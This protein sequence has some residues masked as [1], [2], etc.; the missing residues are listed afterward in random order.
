[1]LLL[2]FLFLPFFLLLPSC[3]CRT[4][5]S[6]LTVL[7]SAINVS[8]VCVCLDEKHVSH[9]GHEDTHQTES[10]DGQSDRRE[11]ADRRED[12]H[13]DLCLRLFVLC[14]AP[15]SAL[16]TRGTGT[17]SGR[18]YVRERMVCEDRSKTRLPAWLF[19]FLLRESKVAKQPGKAER[20]DKKERKRSHRDFAK[21]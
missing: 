12:G 3:R 16:G 10:F 13:D 5:P 4:C 20:I 6:S 7:P 15:S 18:K 19:A 21:V 1:M 11:D 9:R 8:L 14:V 17:R 2:F